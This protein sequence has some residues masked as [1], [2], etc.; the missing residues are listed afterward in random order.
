M[1]TNDWEPDPDIETA[2]R[3][4]FKPMPIGK[5]A[6]THAKQVATK[7]RKKR[8]STFGLDNFD[9]EEILIHSNEKKGKRDNRGSE[10]IQDQAGRQFYHEASA[11]EPPEMSFVKKS[12]GFLASLS[13]TD[14][15]VNLVCNGISTEHPSGKYLAACYSKGNTPLVVFDVYES[16]KQHT[17]DHILF[18][19][20]TKEIDD[21]MHGDQDLSNTLDLGRKVKFSPCGT[22]LV[23]GGKGKTI[24]FDPPADSTGVQKEPEIWSSLLVYRVSDLIDPE[25]AKTAKPAF[26]LSKANAKGVI[27]MEFSRDGHLLVVSTEDKKVRCYHVEVSADADVKAK[28]PARW[29]PP[30]KPQLDGIDSDYTYF[31]EYGIPLYPFTENRAKFDPDGFGAPTCLSFQRDGSELAI[32]VPSEVHRAASVFIVELSGQREPVLQIKFKHPQITDVKYSDTGKWLAIAG[33][34]DRQLLDQNADAIETGGVSILNAHTYDPEAWIQKKVNA[35][36]SISW[37]VADKRIVIGDSAMQATLYAT[38]TWAELAQRKLGGVESD[39]VINQVQI[40]KFTDIF[41]CG[42]VKTPIEAYR[43]SIWKSSKELNLKN[44]PENRDVE[45]NKHVTDPLAGRQFYTDVTWRGGITVNG[46][47]HAD[48][49]VCALTYGNE[50][51]IHDAHSGKRQLC[52]EVTPHPGNLGVIAWSDDGKYLAVGYREGVMIKKHAWKKKVNT[53]SKLKAAHDEKKKK[54]LKPSGIRSGT[55]TQEAQ[56]DVLLN[57]MK[58]VGKLQSTKNLGDLLGSAPSPPTA[59]S[60]PEVELTNGH[61]VTTTTTTTTS[62]KK[63]ELEMEP[64]PE[65]PADP[66]LTDDPETYYVLIYDATDI[67]NDPS[68]FSPEPNT[69]KL[70]QTIPFQETITSLDWGKMSTL[71]SVTSADIDPSDNV[72]QGSCRVFK[73]VE[74]PGKKIRWKRE[75]PEQFPFVAT[76]LSQV[77]IRSQQFL[78]ELCNEYKVPK[79][80]TS[81]FNTRRRSVDDEK[82]RLVMLCERLQQGDDAEAQQEKLY[83]RFTEF[84]VKN[85]NAYQQEA[86]KLSKAIEL[87]DPDS[88]ATKLAKS[89]GRLYPVCDIS[90]FDRIGNMLAVG[91]SREVLV[92]DTSNWTRIASVGREKEVDDKGKPIKLESRD[93]EHHNSVSY[94]EW[95]PSGK[96]LAISRKA[97]S[98]R[99]YDA[100]N[101]KFPLSHRLPKTKNASDLSWSLDDAYFVAICPVSSED[102]HSTAIS[103]FKT[104]GGLPHTRVQQWSTPDGSVG[105]D[106]FPHKTIAAEWSPDGSCLAEVGLTRMNADLLKAGM[107]KTA[108]LERAMSGMVVVEE[109]EEVLEVSEKKKEKGA[110]DLASYFSVW[111]RGFNLNPQLVPLDLDPKDLVEVLREYP[112]T[113]YVSRDY[114]TLVQ[115]LI[116]QQRFKAFQAVIEQFPL[117]AGSLKFGVDSE[118]HKTVTNAFNVANKMRDEAS[119]KMLLYTAQLPEV[120]GS[121]LP[122]IA[123]EALPEI[124]SQGFEDMVVEYMHQLPFHFYKTPLKQANLSEG[125]IYRSSA[126]HLNTSFRNGLIREQGGL[127]GDV[128]DPRGMQI[129]AS[130]VALPNLG[131]LKVLEAFCNANSSIFDNEAMTAVLEVLWEEHIKMWFYIKASIFLVMVIAWIMLV[132]LV[133]S[134][135]TGKITMNNFDRVVYAVVLLINFWLIYEEYRQA[136]GS[137]GGVLKHFSDVWN[138]LDIFSATMMSCFVFF[139]EYDTST[140]TYIFIGVAGTILLMLKSLSFLRGFE[141]TGWLITV[142]T[143][144][145]AD[146]RPFLIVMMVI[147][148]GSSVAF[149]LLLSHAEDEGGDK[150]YSGWW[151]SFFSVFLMSVLGDFDTGLF[152]K[153]GMHPSEFSKLVTQLV[154][155]FVVLFI[156]VV[157]LNAL[158]ALLGDSY[159]KVSE[160]E[161]ANKKKERA[162]LICEYMGVMRGKKRRK[163]NRVTK[164]FHKL[165][166]KE[167]ERGDKGESEIEQ[168]KRIVDELRVEIRGLKDIIFGGSWIRVR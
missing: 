58:M 161:T 13:S 8:L 122:F 61:G 16:D 141:S 135:E 109:E 151:T 96:I 41:I 1:S 79:T 49:S 118:G 71:L 117:C 102:V 142:L 87:T 92:F 89:I 104:D 107:E 9:L 91:L 129:V 4:E 73:K 80:S 12:T 119:L 138:A 83:A 39:S 45:V 75:S 130:H 114:D 148:L 137:P 65:K 63:E 140:D 105:G 85:T 56:A 5:H 70:I 164:F 60:H 95:S 2:K 37:G 25:T 35:V 54:F 116:E 74:E 69:L 160:F 127:W 150:P 14:K 51:L 66:D 159:A 98:V 28:I 100:T 124:I 162:E 23:L 62:S 43:F 50:I 26:N 29:G 59:A 36:T 19:Q 18:N 155:L 123:C 90:K 46:E 44:V 40:N 47:V 152:D 156:T 15:T 125:P 149:N 110:I 11:E 144:N 42:G 22:W 168:F 113:L 86:S 48:S 82:S 111:Y 153:A 115:S 94:L 84:I 128:Y 143:Q 27:A 31:R 33:R 97:V 10:D 132:Q 17:S 53:Y 126:T 38:Y 99:F 158:I 55:P 34:I 72:Q 76:P 57:G 136:K 145:V 147:I 6:D 103:V 133:V 121:S 88:I 134:S 101:G 64:E 146:V 112:E 165:G 167:T 81:V 77:K 32:G 21:G 163:I 131:T 52:R 24:A 20:S 157:A 67:T 139:L 93:V 30:A 120:V 154:F 106:Y 7:K 78:D 3:F 108:I 166:Q 68:K